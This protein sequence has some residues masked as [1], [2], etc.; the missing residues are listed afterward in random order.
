MRTIAHDGILYKVERGVHLSWE[1]FLEILKIGWPAIVT[2][3]FVVLAKL[4]VDTITSVMDKQEA[5][6]RALE[7]RLFDC[8]GGRDSNE[9]T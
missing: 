7:E 1:Q 3:G 6:I 8:L 2:I 9:L 5:R 4:Y